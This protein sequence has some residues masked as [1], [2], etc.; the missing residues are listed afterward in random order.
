MTDALK[1]A[2]DLAAEKSIALKKVNIYCDTLT[3]RNGERIDRESINN[4]GNG[5]DGSFIIQIFARKIIAPL[6]G[7]EPSLQVEMTSSCAI[8][9]W[10]P[11]IPTTFQIDLLFKSKG[12]AIRMKPAVDSAK[13]GIGY[14]CSHSGEIRTSQLAPPRTELVNINYLDLINED[15]TMKE[16]GYRNE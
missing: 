8:I 2:R 7:E 1:T 5:A 13:F 10:I 11:D 4:P 15:G 16:Q 9:F 6:A 3:I 12:E 14:T